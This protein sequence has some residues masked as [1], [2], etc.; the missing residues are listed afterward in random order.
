MNGTEYDQKACYAQALLHKP[1]Y[2]SAWNNLGFYCDGGVVSGIE[3]DRKSVLL[4]K[5]STTSLIMLK[6]GS[7]L[8]WLAVVLLT[9]LNTL[10]KLA[11]CKP[12]STSL[13]H[14]DTWYNLGNG[15]GGLCERY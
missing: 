2:A 10:G 5:P 1:D 14:A 7:I 12:F 3:Y 9:V 15:G 11:T 8:V 4:A 6:H 13:I